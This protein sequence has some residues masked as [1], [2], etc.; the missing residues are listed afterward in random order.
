M[1]ITLKLKDLIDALDIVSIVPPNPI[2]PQGGAG[3]LFVIREGSSC[4]IYSRDALHVARATIGCMMGDGYTGEGSFIFPAGFTDGFRFLKDEEI[5]IE[6]KQEADAF[7]VSWSTG[8]GAG[9]DRASYDPKLMGSCDKDLAEATD[10]RKFPVGLFREALSLAK[11]FLAKANDTRVP[12]HFKTI[13]LFDTTK[14]EWAKGSGN[15]FAA[16]GI[17]AFWFYSDAFKDKGF[18]IHTQHMGFL[19]SFLAKSSGEVT[20]CTGK[21]MTFATDA[22]G[23]VLGWAH[24]SAM[25]AKF[26]YLALSL[27]KIILALPKTLTVDALK[28]IR[29][30]LGPKE[31]KINLTI[32]GY[33]D[34]EVGD[35]TQ[36]HATMVFRVAETRGKAR[37]FPLT[38]VLVGGTEEREVNFNVNIDRL[39]E[40][41]DGVK[42]IDVQLRIAVMPANDQ[43]PKESAMFRT[44][45]EFL[46]DGDGKI[47]GDIR[48]E[49]RPEGAFE[50]RVTR[51]MPSKD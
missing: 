27:D 15:L 50:C 8:S 33:K 38:A 18:S 42:G 43:R 11:P 5:E 41:V 2:T 49:T 34:V 37:S 14:P 47:V 31:D 22:K 24:H 17:Q 36:R 35:K 25:H 21:N 1:K 16:D 19:S 9:A 6:A 28:F 51:F 46:M 23:N 26:S 4:S 30:E 7:T 12:E 32:G 13:Q 29:S 45:D 10:E 44:I 48:A 40:L 3:Y 20:F 39:I